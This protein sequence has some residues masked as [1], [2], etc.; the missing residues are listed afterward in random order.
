[1]TL[2]WLVVVSTV[3][4]RQR[5]AL[6]ELDQERSVLSRGERGHRTG[7]PGCS[8][9]PTSSCRA[10]T[11]S[12]RARGPGIDNGAFSIRDREGAPTANGTFVNS[13]R[14]GPRRIGGSGGRRRDQGG[15]HPD[16]V[17]FALAARIRCADLMS[18]GRLNLGRG[19][20]AGGSARLTAPRLRGRRSC[21]P[22]PLVG[23]DGANRVPGGRD[24]RTRPIAEPL[25]PG[26]RRRRSAGEPAVGPVAVRLGDRRVRSEPGV[27]SAAQRGAGLPVGRTAFRP[28]CWTAF[29]PSSSAF[30]RARWS[31]RRSTAACAR[32]APG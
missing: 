18:A 4:K 32:G 21:R 24:R 17:P 14:L 27:A 6:L 28:A 2:G 11:P 31:I 1:M 8:S 22:A 12:S 29:T 9:S 26:G 7:R 3:D 20:A 5:G 30:R 25:R 16:R 13:R 10:D 15:R 23:R 19:R